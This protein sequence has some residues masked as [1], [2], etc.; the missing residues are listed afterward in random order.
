MSTVTTTAPASNDVNTSAFWERLWRTSG[1]QFVVLTLVAYFIYANG[2]R[3]RTLIAASV[4]GLA[5]LYLMWFAASIRV[6]LM[7]AGQEGWAS[8]VTAASAAVGGLFLLLVAAAVAGLGDFAWACFVLSSFVRAML[9][10]APTFGLWR[11][12]IISNSLFLVGVL[13]V[14]LTVLGGTTWLSGGLWAPDGAYSHF[15]S[16]ILGLAWVVVLNAV[17]WNRPFA[18]SGW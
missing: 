11:A 1:F 16:P 8:A 2:D 3:T 10:M 17:L 15:I 4:S 7:E 13:I 12:G 18:R 6:T 5:V 9:T 14:V